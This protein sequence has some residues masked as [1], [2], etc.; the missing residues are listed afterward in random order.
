MPSHVGVVSVLFTRE[1]ARALG[2]VS[3]FFPLGALIGPT[4]GGFIVTYFSWREIFFVNV[5][6]GAVLL[7]LL[8]IVL[9]AGRRGVP[10]RVDVLGAALMG[11]TL[12]CIMFGLNQFAESGLRSPLP[13]SLLALG[14]LL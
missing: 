14:G 11:T 3:S 13:W 12:L 2:L 10:A 8:W 1:R 6:V 4:L 9:P 5:P 7:L